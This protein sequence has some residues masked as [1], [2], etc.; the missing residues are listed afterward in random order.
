MRPVTWIQFAIS[1]PGMGGLN[2]LRGAANFALELLAGNHEELLRQP[3]RGNHD[4]E[5][6]IGLFIGFVIG[7][8]GVGGGSLTAPV[9]IIVLGFQP[10]IG[11]AT[12]L[13][14]SALVKV[15]VSAVYLWRR[16]VDL[17]ALAYLLGGGLP[18]AVA[19]ALLVQQVRA[20]RSEGWILAAIGA[21]VAASAVSSFMQVDRTSRTTQAR[22][23]LL[24]VFALP[25][26]LETGFSSAGAGALGS[27]ILFNFTALPPA[28]V[29]GTDLLFGLAISAVGGGIHAAAGGCNWAA[30]TRLVPAGILGAF[31]GASMARHLPSGR[32]RKGV[33]S[34][35]ACLGVVL[36]CKGIARL[37]G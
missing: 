34:C 35:A 37:H 32:L 15:C 24:S 30:L 10:R 11:V 2:R 29:V 3:I 28:V 17:R 1:V 6:L 12:A 26:G 33:L 4:M 19:G 22:R 9:L 20:N 23:Q 13:V 14:F 8:T 21:I 5:I 25:I 27:I 31:I 36:L 16:Q 18:G 7:S